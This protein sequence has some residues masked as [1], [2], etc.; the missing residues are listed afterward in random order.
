MIEIKK[1]CIDH[2]QPIS[3][4]LHQLNELGQEL[5]LFVIKEGALVGTLTDGD[6]RRGLLRRISM[7]EAVESIMFTAFSF[8]RGGSCMLQEIEKVRSR[9]VNILPVV[10]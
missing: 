4:A 2:R 5:T 3:D 9:G 6:V 7:D 8:I 1:H 10:D